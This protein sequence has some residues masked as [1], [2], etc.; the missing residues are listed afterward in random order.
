MNRLSYVA[1]ALSLAA[2]AP[3]MAQRGPTMPPSSAQAAP[4]QTAPDQ[5]APTQAA[6][7]DQAATSA[8]V[9]TGMPVKDNT[10]AT[11]GAV[12]SVQPGPGGAPTATIKMGAKVFSVATNALAVS[13]GAAT[14]NASQAQIEGMLPKS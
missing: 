12:A 14:I 7:A 1:V 6:P 9:T 3:A 2:A 5:T 4:A 8:A 11:I 10:G 13:G